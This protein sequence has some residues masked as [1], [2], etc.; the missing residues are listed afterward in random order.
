MKGLKLNDGNV[1]PQIG[2]GVFLIPND[3]STYNAVK[4][5]LQSGYRHIDTAAAYFN[6]EEV[7]QAVRESGIKREEIFVTSKLWLQDYGY[8]AAKKGID[9]SL[10]KLGV[11]Y[12]DL[13]LL[14]Q[15]YFDTIGAWQAL[16]E[17]QKEGKIKSIGV[18]N[19]T[20]RLF[21]DFISQIKIKP[22]VN[23]VECNPYFQQKEL[24][25]VLKK[26]GTLLEAWYPLGHGNKELLNN[27]ILVKLAQKYHKSAV[28]IILRWHI[29]EGNIALPKATSEAHI[30]DN[31]DTFDFAWSDEE[32]AQIRALD[33]G[34]GTHNPEAEGV[35]EMLLKNYKVHD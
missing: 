1:I 34:K 23:Q 14:H 33:T 29:Q 19:M 27:E 17:A 31:I 16:V 28:Q 9:T 25:E 8:E 6:E 20:P 15:P 4:M 30:K 2:F 18:S 24:R 10:R 3:G 5:A 13:Y 12:I 35:G 22:A 26:H 32:M 7:G 11:D 21:N